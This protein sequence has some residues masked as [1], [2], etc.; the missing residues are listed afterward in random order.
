[1]YVGSLVGVVFQDDISL[2]GG[3]PSILSPLL[4][5]LLDRNWLTLYR[6]V[7]ILSLAIPQ[8][9]RTRPGV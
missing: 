8:P 9:F 2:I 6:R 1:M 4:M 7:T 5:P 3:H